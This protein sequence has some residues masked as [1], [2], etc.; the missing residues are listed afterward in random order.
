LDLTINNPTTGTD[1][2]TACKSFTWIDG[3]TYTT[4]NNTAT[5]NII[6]G[7]ANGCDSLVTLN[8]T[9]NTVDNSITNNSPTL[10]SNAIGATYQ[11]LDCNNENA[12]ISGET[13]QSFTAT[14]NGDYAVEVT[15]NSCTDTSI[16]VT[17]NNVGI[18]DIQPNIYNLSIYPNPSHGIFTVEYNYNE[19]VQIEVLTIHGKQILKSE[20]TEN[21]NVINLSGHPVGMYFINF[22]FGDFQK[23]TRKIIVN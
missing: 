17:V 2:Q 10:T 12:P 4:N 6:G 20:L 7:A 15:Q 3:I 21:S 23:V 1:V 14:V 9:V 16:C 8:L 18:E 22:S 19:P 11:W 5:F 13:N